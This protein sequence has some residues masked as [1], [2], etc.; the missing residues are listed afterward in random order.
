MRALESLKTDPAVLQ[1][2]KDAVAP[3]VPSSER[4]TAKEQFDELAVEDTTPLERLRFF[5]SL[6]MSGQDWLDVEPF[7]ADVEKAVRSANEAP[8][9]HGDLLLAWC[10]WTGGHITN[11]H[12]LSVVHVLVRDHLLQ[13]TVASP[14][15]RG[16]DV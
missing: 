12:F 15:R 16:A 5:C 6:A 9:W 1:A 4:R 7:F 14:D 11:D 3:S 8:E 2:L 10:E 13:T